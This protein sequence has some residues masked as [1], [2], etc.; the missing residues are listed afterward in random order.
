M[1]GRHQR[2]VTFVIVFQAKNSL[3]TLGRDSKSLDAKRGGPARQREPRSEDLSRL[4]ILFYCK[5]YWLEKNN[6]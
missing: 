2:Q 3:A 6:E 1:N 4:S 5:K